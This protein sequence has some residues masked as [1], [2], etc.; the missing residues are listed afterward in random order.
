MKVLNVTDDWVGQL[1]GRQHSVN[2]KMMM[3]GIRLIDPCGGNPHATEPK[4]HREWV[5][6]CISIVGANEINR[7]LWW[8]VGRQSD[9]RKTKRQ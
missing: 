5:S 1:F 3:P 9:Y 8:R 7:S 4:L 6:D 2:E